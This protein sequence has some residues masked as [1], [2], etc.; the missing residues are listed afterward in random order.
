MAHSDLS[1]EDWY[2]QSQRDLKAAEHLLAG[3]YFAH[4]AVLA[5]LSVEK[6]LKGWL[7][8]RS[9]S[10]PPPTHDLTVLSTRLGLDRGAHGWTADLQAALDDLGN[11]SILSLYR[12]DRPFGHPVSDREDAARERVAAAR[13]I[14]SW[15]QQA[16][17][18]PAR[19]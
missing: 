3:D 2:A 1:A 8:E 6:V 5:H 7:R 19:S 11:A 9:G 18:P 12:P 14:G 16:S 15:V 10:A 4:A 13:T 17:G